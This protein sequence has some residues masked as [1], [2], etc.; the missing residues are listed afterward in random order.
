[1]GKITSIVAA[2]SIVLIL[3]VAP[4]AVAQ[5][6]TQHNLVSDGAV[7]AECLDPNL[8]NA[9]GLAA[10]PPR[11]GGSPTMERAR[12]RSIVSTPRSSPCVHGSGCGR[13]ER[14]DRDGA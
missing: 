9:W 14:T 11:R 2:L 13:S 10:S 4:P 1:M 7:P 8:V 5:F 6:Y 12:P 3:G